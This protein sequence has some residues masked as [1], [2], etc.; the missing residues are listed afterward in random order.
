MRTKEGKGERDYLTDR[1]N[2]RRL[3]ETERR[4]RR[5]KEREEEMESYNIIR[6]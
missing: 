6:L 5:K 4:R 2:W 1:E 3:S